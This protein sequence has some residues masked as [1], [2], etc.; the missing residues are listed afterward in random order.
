ME[1]ALFVSAC[2][3]CRGRIDNVRLQSGLPC[4]LCLPEEVLSDPKGQKALRR[5]VANLLIRNDK[6]LYYSE[7]WDIDRK[8]EEFSKMFTKLTASR[9]WSAQITWARRSMRG[10][11]FSIIAPTGVGKTTFLS[12]LATHFAGEGKRVLM[13]APTALLARQT[14]MWVRR[15]SQKLGR[16]IRIAEIH[17]EETKSSRDR[18]VEMVKESSAQIVILTSMGLSR[19]FE[20]LKKVGFSVILVDD[21][22]ALLRKSANINRVLYLLGYDEQIQ[23]V[24]SSAI[25]L[26]FKLANLYSQR[27]GDTDQAKALTI[28]YRK[29]KNKIDEYKKSKEQLGQL[30]LSS[31]TARPRGLKVKLFRELLNFEAGSSTGY[32][33]NIVD[34]EARL[35]S[36][37]PESA[38]HKTVEWV[39]KLGKGGLIFV[40]REYGMAFME[41][42]TQELSRNGVFAYHTKGA[43]RKRL[44]QFANGEIHVLIGSASYYGKL[45]RGIDLPQSVKY[46]IFVGIPKFK[47]NLEDEEIS[48]MGLIRLL[49]ATAD[50]IPD[51]LGRQNL[52]E[53]AT[54]LRKLIQNLSP[55]D[56]SLITKAI[57]D[58]QVLEGYLGR[59]QSEMGEGRRLFHY[60]LA[61]P[62]VRDR[63]K[64]SDQLILQEEE[65]GLY[66]LTP[67]VKTYIQASG[68][69]S[70]LF[71]GKLTK[72]LSI[73]LVDNDRVMSALK[74]ALQITSSTN[75]WYKENEI[76]VEKLKLRLEEDRTASEH[77]VK[78]KDL[79]K[80]AL[81]VVESP[82]KARTIANF[83]G[84]PG[85]RYLEG[86]VF[87]EVVINGLLF[88]IG[89]S[90]GHVLD[91]P[92]DAT[93]Q[94]NYGVLRVDHTFLPMYDFM[95]RCLS[96]GKQFTGTVD[97]CPY[98]GSTELRRS[99]DVIKALQRTASD[100][101]AVYIATDPDSEGEK[102]AWD[103]ALMLSPYSRKVYRAKFHEVTPRAILRALDEATSIDTRLV[104]A[105]MVRR[106]D[107]RWIGYGLTELLT[108]NQTR[109]FEDGVERNRVPAGR[110][111]VPVLGLV[112]KRSREN[113]AKKVRKFAARIRISPLE[114]LRIVFKK[115]YVKLT[116]RE[117]SDYRSSLRG[118]RVSVSEVE[119]QTVP[120]KSPPPFT[121]DTVLAEVSRRFGWSVAEI[122]R[123]LQDLF[124]VGLITYHRTDHTHVSATGK[125][126]A[127][128]YI[129]S[130]WKDTWKSLHEPKSWG[131]EGAH[132]CIRPTKP[133]N[134][135]E[136]KRQIDLLQIPGAEIL[137]QRHLRLYDLIFRRFMAGQMRDCVLV[138]QKAVL[139][140]NELTTVLEGYS[141]VLQE[142]FNLVY[143]PRMV[144]TLVKGSTYEVVSLD[145]AVG[146]EAPLPTEGEVVQYM[147]QK[148]IGRPSTYATTIEKLK[149]H[150][151]VYATKR[152]TLVSTNLGETVYRYL[153]ENL[154]ELKTI[155]DEAYTAQLF[156]KLQKV[157]SGEEDYLNVMHECYSDFKRI[158]AM[159]QG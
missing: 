109:M 139:T 47:T 79:M 52:F 157:E 131:E 2:P 4:K 122:M 88:I 34:V 66:V 32:L 141:R 72:G 76:D 51:P 61:Q 128:V 33:R 111:Q 151:Y 112:I 86:R 39:K 29:L 78:N 19:A 113:R 90:G 62:G 154:D 127:R 83:F 17:G 60:G 140:L 97:K 85:R 75:R 44:D 120:L 135:D 142:G 121:T 155:L 110:V 67:D 42:L 108:K 10:E 26:R 98:C 147:K 58:G 115:D 35:A 125:E 63:L 107:D 57:Q 153:D 12:V 134:A 28:E 106:V 69:S 64:Q 9:P 40:S 95:T 156:S 41:R 59:V 23:E 70:R 152:N 102:I 8:A 158:E 6:M 126:I 15:N 46:T 105:Q 3:N 150:G 48:P 20:T 118:K 1:S 68:R 130:T 145:Y 30:I 73:V 53:Q 5:M 77:A 7:L 132:E 65:T 100:V 37:F 14:A 129:E 36:P 11:S 116:R 22:D 103:V 92:Y 143:P 27:L 87:Y 114:E 146:T 16:E 136:L 149:Q 101:S 117:L 45:V 80:S 82:N 18:A 99:S 55:G 49:Y 24:A 89:S 31:A 38:V 119:E 91:L 81:L 159:Y 84:R 56:I 21:V 71:S 144:P 123:R 43:F 93:G 13:V 94:D 138:R 25:L 148:G 96:C 50:F 137:D 133:L 104:Q 54:K 124:E 74:R